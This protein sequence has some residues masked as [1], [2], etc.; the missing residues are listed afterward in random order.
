MSKCCSLPTDLFVGGSLSS[1]ILA[2]HHKITNPE[3]E[4]IIIEGGSRVGG[5]NGSYLAKNG[6]FFDY[7]MRV[8]YECNIKELDDI[9]VRSLPAKDIIF[10]KDNKKDPAACYF[11]GNL[12]SN[13]PCLDL[14]ALSCNEKNLIMGQIN[15]SR[16]N[17]TKSDYKNCAE[18][19]IDKLGK[20]I[21]EKYLFPILEN[22]YDRKAE[23]L[24]VDATTAHFGLNE[25]VILFEENK[26]LQLMQDEHLRM[27]LAFPN[28]ENLPHPYSQRSARGIYPTR[29]GMQHI[30]DGL[31]EN[32]LA[33]GGK[34][35]FNANIQSVHHNNGSISMLNYIDKNS[36]N[37]HSIKLQA[38][39]W[40]A[41]LQLLA[42]FLGYTSEY[43]LE[44]G[45]RAHLV[46]MIVNKKLNLGE[47]YY[48]FNFDSS[49]EIFRVANYSAYCPN[50]SSDGLYRATVEYWSNSESID[51]QKVNDE[52]LRMAII[53]EQHKIIFQELAAGPAFPLQSVKNEECMDDIRKY[54]HSLALRNVLAFGQSAKKHTF[55]T[56]DIL[57]AAFEDYD[58]FRFNLI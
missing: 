35:I 34:I 54:V 30:I 37:I 55:Y 14:R 13:S 16:K 36:G 28:Q 20:I 18:Y 27:R 23:E 31:K 58:R 29:L 19:L 41:P 49:Y 38:L 39:F 44:R 2:T 42:K 57:R 10:L 52:L 40:G 22:F 45:K 15:N 33:L 11:K 9:V 56:P 43:E 47:L 17:I 12:Q 25:R 5:D 26:T 4:V 48:L 24:T 7:G 1:L 53:D 8:Y 51:I 21:S 50:S 6:E 46:H 32:F 3:N